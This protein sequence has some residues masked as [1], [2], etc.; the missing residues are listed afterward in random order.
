MSSFLD[1]YT[2]DEVHG[3]SSWFQYPEKT[4]EHICGVVGGHA[5]VCGVINPCQTWPMPHM[6]LIGEIG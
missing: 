3:S 1:Y 6:T 2:N 4:A 5:V